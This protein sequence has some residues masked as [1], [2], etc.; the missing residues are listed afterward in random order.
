MS[1]PCIVCEIRHLVTA[2]LC[3]CGSRQSETEPHTAAISIVLR[4][5]ASDGKRVTVTCY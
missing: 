1:L 5:N 2:Y 3:V 4:I